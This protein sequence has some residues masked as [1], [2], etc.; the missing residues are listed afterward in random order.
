[1]K[2]IKVNAIDFINKKCKCCNHTI[3]SAKIDFEYRVSGYDIEKIVEELENKYPLTSYC[4]K[5]KITHK[6][7]VPT[8]DINEVDDLI[9]EYYPDIA[10]IT[11]EKKY[12]FGHNIF[13]DVSIAVEK[14]LKEKGYTVKI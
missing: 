6:L 9:E 14:I 12:G 8:I 11:T 1:M 3:Q 4:D 10:D 7:S 5:C 2:D 13:L